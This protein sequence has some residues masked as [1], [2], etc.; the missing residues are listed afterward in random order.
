MCFYA[1]FCYAS[2]IYK[3]A[4]KVFQ[5]AQN[6][7]NKQAT[8]G[9]GDIGCCQKNNLKHRQHRAYPTNWLRKQKPTCLTALS[10]GI[11]TKVATTPHLVWL[12]VST[13]VMSIYRGPLLT[14]SKAGHTHMSKDA[15]TNSKR[16]MGFWRKQSNMQLV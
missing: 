11:N 4:Q 3:C 14:C 5:R 2:V 1:L 6:V 12:K 8:K 13:F 10:S 7:Q 9:P 16:S 15:Q